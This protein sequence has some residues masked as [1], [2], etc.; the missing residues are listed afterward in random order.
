MTLRAAF[1]ALALVIAL[2]AC[3]TAMARTWDVPAK[4]PTIQAAIDTAASGDTVAVAAGT[5][6]IIWS[7]RGPGG[8]FT[9]RAG[10]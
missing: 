5:I 3:P 2:L 9:G 6:G 1:S 4:I 7:G 10:G 8:P